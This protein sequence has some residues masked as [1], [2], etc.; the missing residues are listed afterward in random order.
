MSN[1]AK[2]VSHLSVK[3]GRF[4]FRMRVPRELIEA[5]GPEVSQALGDVTKAQ[6]G[7]RARE[8]GADWASKFLTEKHCL[9]LAAP[10]VPTRAATPAEAKALGQLAARS[11]LLEDL[12]ARIGGTFAVMADSPDF[13]PGRPLDA[14]LCDAVAGR[15]LSGVRMQ[16]EQWLGTQGL[17]L[18]TDPT[19]AAEGWGQRCG[20]PVRSV[21][22]RLQAV[23]WLRHIQEDAAQLPAHGRDR[24]GLRWGLADH[25][26]C[27]H[28][29]RGAGRRAQGVRCH[30]P[31]QRGAVAGRP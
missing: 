10:A 15:D 29:A 24:A 2:K 8:L 25:R 19:D 3:N 12:Q 4:Y 5:F 14:A 13:G 20:G 22:R 6:A 31:A 21:V 28:G 16:A 7:V 27:H 1:V 9:G 30:H 18:P 11:M 23:S 17:V 26:G